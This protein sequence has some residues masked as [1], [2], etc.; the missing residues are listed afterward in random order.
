MEAVM[1][2]M[3]LNAAAGLLEWTELADR[4]PLR[5]ANQA[6]SDL[7]DGKFEGAVVL[8]P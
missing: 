2:A 8:T 6:L 5:Q 1:H 7:R 4:Q 3:M